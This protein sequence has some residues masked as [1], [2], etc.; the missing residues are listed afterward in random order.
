MAA[1]DELLTS[2][3]LLLNVPFWKLEEDELWWTWWERICVPAAFAVTLDVDKASGVDFVRGTSDQRPRCR[4]V[5][6]RT[7]H[8]RLP[9]ADQETS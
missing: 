1:V 7:S 3:V 6:T 5:V 8:P 2:T 9:A 4:V